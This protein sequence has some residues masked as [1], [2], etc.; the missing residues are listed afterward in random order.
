MRKCR[1]CIDNSSEEKKIA[2]KLYIG[3]VTDS[4]YCIRESNGFML[5]YKRIENRNLQWPKDQDEVKKL[6]FQEIRWLLEC[7]SIQQ[8]KAIKLAKT[9]YLS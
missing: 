9:G 1:I 6:T 4:C 3:I 8:P 7:L 2:T 5:L